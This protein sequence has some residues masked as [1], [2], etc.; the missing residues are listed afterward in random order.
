MKDFVIELI[1]AL[2]L[3]AVEE[4]S[5]FE[6]VSIL[7]PSVLFIS[8]LFGVSFFLRE[9][10]L[11]QTIVI[12]CVVL[13]LFFL[14]YE[15]FRQASNISMA[16]EKINV[17]QSQL[18]ELLTVSDLVH[19]ELLVD[20]EVASDMLAGLIYDL[21]DEQKQALIFMGWLIAEN[22]AKIKQTVDDRYQSLGEEVTLGL[23]NATQ[24]IISSR[25]PTEKISEDILVR[26][27]D[28][29]SQRI[30][31][32]MTAFNQEIDQSLGNFQEKI[33]LFIQSQLNEY[34]QKLIKITQKNTDDLEN[35]ADRARISFATQLNRSSRASLR[36]L[37]DT[38]RS[39]DDIGTELAGANLRSLTSD[40]KNL[41]A[42]IDETQKKNDILFKYNECIRLVGFID[43]SGKEKQCRIEMNRRL[44]KL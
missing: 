6:I 13:T 18:K 30:E 27:E 10:Y 26:I 12:S 2:P 44:E 4:R 15:L 33:N 42:L 19:L 39:V 22:E 37:E 28:D 40:V 43:F 20:K 31:Q 11:K 7:A 1:N 25:M 29:V 16:D 41:S 23:N 8:V 36:Q 14:P 21:S 32:K 35:Y 34:E 5:W 3:N 17:T 9:K 38:K 24:E